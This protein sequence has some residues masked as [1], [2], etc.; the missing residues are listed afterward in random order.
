MT[1]MIGFDIYRTETIVINNITYTVR[2]TISKDGQENK[3][4]VSNESNSKQAS[5][6]FTQEVANDFKHYQGQELQGHVFRMIESDINT[7]II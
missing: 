3:L 1:Q 6:Q 7:G 5:Y 4:L 2:F